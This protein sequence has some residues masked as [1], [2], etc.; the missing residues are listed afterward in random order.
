MKRVCLGGGWPQGTRAG[1]R[2]QW[3]KNPP[4]DRKSG[5]HGEIV[6]LKWFA[7]C[8]VTVAQA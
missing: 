4:A 7:G 5:T 8:M 3:P 1:H 2:A 6:K